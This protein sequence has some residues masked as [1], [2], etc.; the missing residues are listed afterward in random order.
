MKKLGYPDKIAENIVV[1]PTPEQMGANPD[2]IPV[3]MEQRSFREIEVD[4]VTYKIGGKFD[5]V[6]EGRLFDAKSTS[7]YSYLL[8]RKD[9]DL[10]CRAASIAGSTP[11]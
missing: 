4:G 10:R 8:G 11:S 5:L 3:W 2:I 7:V 1:N 6:L 9:D